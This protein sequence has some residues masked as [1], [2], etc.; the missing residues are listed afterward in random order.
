[1]KYK[2]WTH[3][4]QF[5]DRLAIA[6]VHFLRDTRTSTYL[7]FRNA[8]VHIT[9]DAISTIPYHDLPAGM[10]VWRK[11]I[12]DEDIEI[13]GIQD[14][15]ELNECPVYRFIKRISGIPPELDFVP[16]AELAGSHYDL[17]TRL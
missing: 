13:M 3:T 5:L 15:K 1:M 17:L 8:I 16:L 14:E 12:K 9:A 11:Q 2:E 6:D 10:L 7:P 4:L